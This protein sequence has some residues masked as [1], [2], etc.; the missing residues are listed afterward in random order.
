MAVH[1]IIPSFGATQTRCKQDVAVLGE[2]VVLVLRYDGDKL[3]S[4][5]VMSLESYYC[6]GCCA[7]QVQAN[8]TPAQRE[9]AYERAFAWVEVFADVRESF[10]VYLDTTDRAQREAAFK[11]MNQYRDAA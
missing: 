6:P 10:C 1:H 3:P 7:A 8:L 4:Q 9:S 5:L 11:L 2:D